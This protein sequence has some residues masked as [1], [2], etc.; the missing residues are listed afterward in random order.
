M[1]QT[2]LPRSRREILGSRFLLLLYTEYSWRGVV[3]GARQQPVECAGPPGP[4]LY[5][6]L[7]K[8]SNRTNKFSTPIGTDRFCIPMTAG[9]FCNLLMQAISPQG[10]PCPTPWQ[11]GGGGNRVRQRRSAFP[12]T[13]LSGD[14]FHGISQNWWFP[15][16]FEGC[17]RT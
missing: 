9:K 14:Q 12:V 8:G 1:Y 6:V 11:I 17:V 4:P 15:K 3:G 2:S 16:F 7:L 5:C 10:L 13:A